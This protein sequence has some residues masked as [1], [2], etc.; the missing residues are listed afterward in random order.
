MAKSEK[1]TRATPTY[2]LIRLR[3]QQLIA[4]PGSQKTQE[5]TVSR[6]ECESPAEW[7]QII[8]EIAEISGVQVEHQEGGLV[9]IVWRDYFEA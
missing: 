7:Q 5:L 6:L 2:Q 3:L 8:E 9:R 1:K 4:A